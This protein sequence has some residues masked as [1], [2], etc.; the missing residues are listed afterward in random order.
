MTFEVKD[1]NLNYFNKDNE[2]F[3]LNNNLDIFIEPVLSMGVENN[4]SS[5][6]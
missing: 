2:F 6:G 4:L 1:K 3:L 5:A